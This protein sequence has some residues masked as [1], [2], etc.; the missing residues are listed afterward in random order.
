MGEGVR[1]RGVEERQ[2]AK[3]GKESERQ[4]GGGKGGGRKKGGEV[5][6]EGRERVGGK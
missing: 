6:I 2:R 1:S 4:V 3:G 5:S